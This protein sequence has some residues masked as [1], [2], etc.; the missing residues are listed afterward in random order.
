MA[1][2]KKYKVYSR[3]WFESEDVEDSRTDDWEFMGETYAVSE[4]KAINNVRFRTVGN[5]SQYKPAAVGGHWENGLDWK[6]EE[7]EG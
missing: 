7:V 5:I 2:K 1:D 4:D 6:A 3:Y